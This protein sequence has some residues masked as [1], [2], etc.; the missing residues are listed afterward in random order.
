MLT[1]DGTKSYDPDKPDGAL[2]YT[3]HCEVL[4]GAANGASCA[5]ALAPQGLNEVALESS[6]KRA[7]QSGSARCQR[8]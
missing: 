3:W 5:T 1:L 6:L 4:V 2:N 7:K 8:G